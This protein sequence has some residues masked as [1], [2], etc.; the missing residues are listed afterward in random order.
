MLHDRFGRAVDDLRIS[1]TDRC[2]FRCVYCMPEHGLRWLPRKEILSYEEI[3]RAVAVMLR[4]GITTVRLTGGEPL[5]RPDVEVLVRQL[6][7]LGP[8]LDLSLTT[9]GFFL[10]EKAGALARAGLT[11]VNVSL[12][13]MHPDRFARIARV[14]R[15]FFARVLD[16][17]DAALAAGLGPVKVN[18][19][20][21]KGLNE[22]EVLDFA[23]LARQKAVQVRFIEFMPLDGEGHW[24][25]DLVVP[26]SEVRRQVAQVYPLVP[27]PN[28][29]PEPA[30]RYRFADG[31][32]GVGFVN[33]VTEPFCG[34][35]NRIRLTADGQLRTCLFSTREHD[36]KA[37]LRSG[38]RDEAMRRFVVQAVWAKEPGHRINA[39]DFIRPERTMSAIGG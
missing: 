22:D 8:G 19:V 15:R 3:L 10:P 9:N 17:L 24:S 36:L 26:G 7:A 4:L 30:A 35:C 25:P 18:V 33:S 23:R 16:G 5:V 1:I 34:S 14:D 2:N 12:D 31:A 28:P 21:M 37:L 39:P 11:R 27:V 29:R 20:L 13:S 32:G 6:R 38:A